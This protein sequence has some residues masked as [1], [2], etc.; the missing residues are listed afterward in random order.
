MRVL[1]AGQ[2]EAGGQP[3]ASGG[4][5]YWTVYTY[6]GLGRTKRVELADG[7]GS[8]EYLYTARR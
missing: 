1:A 3:R 4:P 8:T 6:E 5:Q 7:S 2:G